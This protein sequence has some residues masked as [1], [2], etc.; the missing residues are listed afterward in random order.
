MNYYKQNAKN[1]I[2]NTVNVDM[3]D[4]QNLLTKILPSAGNV[5]DIG[6]GSGRDLK[7]FKELGFNAIGIE[8]CEELANFAKDFSGCDVLQVGINEFESDEKFDGIWACASLLH[9]TTEE[10]KKAF[11]KI[12]SLMK[13]TSIFYCSFKYGEFEGERN[14]RF[15]NDQTEETIKKLLVSDLKISKEWQTED[16]RPDRDEKWLNLIITKSKNPNFS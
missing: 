13:D 11:I 9:L 1:F 5:L 2:E 4:I 8:P 3:S 12:S 6:C 14:G 16:K 10:L 7:S 15:F